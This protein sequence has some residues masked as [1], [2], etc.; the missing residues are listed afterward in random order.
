MSC[1]TIQKLPI[2]YV[3]TTYP[4]ILIRIPD[5]DNIGSY[6]ALTN[7][8]I[9]M[10]V[11]KRPDARIEHEFT[12][13][14]DGSDPTKINTESDWVVDIS[15]MVYYTDL[16]IKSPTDVNSQTK[17]MILPIENVITKV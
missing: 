13:T 3:G 1:E 14:I 5:P 7:Y 12:I 4:S 9:T 2:G 11:R 17:T 10:Q 16:H 15:E 6:L 8:V